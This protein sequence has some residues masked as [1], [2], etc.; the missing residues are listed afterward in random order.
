MYT[1][2]V[3]REQLQNALETPEVQAF[4]RVIRHCEG[5]LGPAGYH[6]LFGHEL[7]DGFTDHPRRKITKIVKG[8][9]LTSSAAGAY[10]ILERTWDWIRGIYKWE[11]FSPRSQDEA[12]VALIA[13]RGALPAVLAG[14]VD[15]ALAKCNKEWASLPG[16]TYGQPTARLDR[17]IALYA[18]YRAELSVQV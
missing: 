16:A 11:D 4:L 3:N 12:A 18:K 14:R 9:T 6:T 13:Y 17:T 7:F 2:K 15:E 8:G 1:R 10:Q 5:T